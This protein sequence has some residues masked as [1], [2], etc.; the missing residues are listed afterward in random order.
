MLGRGQPRA[1]QIDFA[2]SYE[3]A[4]KTRRGKVGNTLDRRSATNTRASRS[5]ARHGSAGVPIGMS[6]PIALASGHTTAKP[7]ISRARRA[8]YETRPP[9][10]RPV[11]G[12]APVRGDLLRPL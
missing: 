6:T 3:G 10:D 1:T 9:D 7:A 4:S 12:A 8:P 11:A 2:S 5:A